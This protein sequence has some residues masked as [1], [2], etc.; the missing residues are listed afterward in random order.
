MFPDGRRHPQAGPCSQTLRSTLLFSRGSPCSIL[1]F[2]TRRTDLFSSRT[3]IRRS[4]DKCSRI[5]TRVRDLC[6]LSRARC[7]GR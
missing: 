2:S 7:N 4:P 5:Q 6:S 1:P 3:L